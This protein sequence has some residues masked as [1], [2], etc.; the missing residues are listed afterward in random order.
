MFISNRQGLS[1]FCEKQNKRHGTT[2]VYWHR[3][4]NTGFAD[5]IFY[6]IISSCP[7]TVAQIKQHNSLIAEYWSAKSFSPTATM[8]N[9]IFFSSSPTY[10]NTSAKMCS[11]QTG[12]DDN[13]ISIRRQ[14]FINIVRTAYIVHSL[15]IP[16]LF[17]WHTNKYDWFICFWRPLHIIELRNAVRRSHSSIANRNSLIIYSIEFIYFLLCCH[18]LWLSSKRSSE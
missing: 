11:S 9:R 1:S 10:A 18:C 16:F 4:A 7:C 5:V 2:I 6:W 14:G 8:A 12:V 15:E 17:H 3:N 13:L